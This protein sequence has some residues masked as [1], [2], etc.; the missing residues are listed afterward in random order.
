MALLNVN[1]LTKSF[2]GLVAVDNCSFDVDENSIVGIMGPN[3]SGKTTVLN[4]I[5]GFLKPN[6]GKVTFEGEDITNMKTHRVVQK[7]IGR[8][9]QITR[10]F[11]KLTVLENLFV[12]SPFSI[13]NS[14]E[15]ALELLKLTELLELK[16]EPAENLSYGQQKLLEF[17]RIS[18]V[19]PKL[20]L[21]DEPVAGIN[22]LL[23]TKL[24]NLIKEQRSKENK[25]FIIVEH[26]I[27]VIKDICDKVIVLSQGKKIA[28]GPYD[29][30]VKSE[31]VLKT[32]FLRR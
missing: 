14:L 30:V 6:Y 21:L 22:P 7:G 11:K 20:F 26:S 18:M 13:V 25:S 24:M 23:Q 19:N 31:A 1:N 12:S 15:R 16:D 5:T 28:E 2:G 4:L 8:T 27:N 10:V 32:Y 29:E 3:G 17:A 9:F